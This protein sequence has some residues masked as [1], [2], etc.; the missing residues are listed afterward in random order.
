M[1]DISTLFTAIGN[2]F[3]GSDWSQIVRW[4]FWILLGTVAVGG[5]YCARFGKK[6]LLLQSVCAAMNVMAIYLVASILYTSFPFLRSSLNEPPFLSV[7]DQGLLLVDISTLS[8]SAGA[9]LLLRLM[10]LVLLVNTADSFCSSGK[11]MISW[12]FFQSVATVIALFTYEIVIAGIQIIFPRLLS[13]Y[14]IIPV[15]A[16]VIISILMIC[17]KFIFTV[18]ITGGNPYYSAVYKFFTVNR[19][20]SLFTTSALSFLLLLAVTGVLFFT[21]SSTLL[22]ATA[23]T[24][25]LGIILCMLVLCMYLFST[26]YIDRKRG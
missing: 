1:N 21:G 23:N 11:T 18:V 17:A 3:T 10:V 5:V 16:V 8:L 9:G 2:F 13:R 12:L 22:Y 20:G 24:T 6:T 4:P 7:S 15:V 26:F 25:A 14:A 19:G